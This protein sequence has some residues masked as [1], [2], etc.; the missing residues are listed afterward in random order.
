M[1]RTDTAIKLL[2]LAEAATILKISK[3]TLHRMIQ[4]R[5]IPAFKVGGQW[6]I[7]ES[8]FQEWVQVEE[9]SAPKDGQS[10]NI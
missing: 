10:T 6:R 9:N 7:L 2:T 4:H 5:Q 1:K 3:R 8:R